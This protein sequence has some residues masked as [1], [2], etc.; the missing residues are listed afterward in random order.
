MRSLS[1]PDPAHALP[2]A[3]S[4][5][6]DLARCRHLPLTHE[7]DRHGLLQPALPRGG[8]AGGIGAGVRAGGCAALAGR[9]RRGA[10]IACASAAV[11][12]AGQAGGVAAWFGRPMYW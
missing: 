4:A 5:L 1:P 2:D 8:T 7:Q 10:A 11:S 12:S 6:R 9:A 3:G